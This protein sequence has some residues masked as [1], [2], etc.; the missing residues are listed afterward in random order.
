[1]EK[2]ILTVNGTRREIECDPTTPLIYI[3]RD[4]LG[5]TGSKLGCA[6]EQCGSCTILVNGEAVQCCVRAVS[7][8]TA[9]EITTIEGLSKDTIG[10][11]VQ[12]AF[13]ESNAAQCGYCT[14]G[15]ISSATAL[16]K[17][18]AFPEDHEIRKA[19]D[20][21]LCRCGSHNRV[22]DAVKKASEKLHHGR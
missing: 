8:F 11:V 13:I 12:E 14:P 9:D 2:M 17:K 19:L 22:L 1:M 6:Q 7:D 18:S 16:L 3:L 15:I 5:L 10:R 20:K 21:N 4:K